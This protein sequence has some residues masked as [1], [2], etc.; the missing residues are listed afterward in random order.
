MKKN[1]YPFLAFVL[2]PLIGWTQ[3]QLHQVT[4]HEL[5]QSNALNP[6]ALSN[7]AWTITFPN[8]YNE[9]KT[10]QLSINQ[11]IRKDVSGENQLIIDEYIEDLGA[12]NNFRNVFELETFGI[13]YRN[14]NDEQWT[15]RHKIKSDISFQYPKALIELI[16]NTNPTSPTLNH[17]IF[18]HT[19]HEL[20][21]G[22]AKKLDDGLQIG[23]CFKILNGINHISANITDLQSIGND[24]KGEYLLHTSDLLEKDDLGNLNFDLTRQF[25]LQNLFSRNFG[26][27][28]DLGVQ[29]QL[30]N[31]QI[32]MS[33]LDVGQLFWNT[34]ISNFYFEG[35]FPVKKMGVAND[36]LEGET[37]FE[38]TTDSLRSIFNP[39]ETQD[40][41]I[42]NLAP[43]FYGRLSYMNNSNWEFHAA[44]YGSWFQRAFYPAISLITRYQVVRNLKLGVSYSI[45]NEEYDHLG[46][47]VVLNTDK[48][49]LFAISNDFINL[50]DWQNQEISDIQ[51]GINWLFGDK[52]L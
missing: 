43:K 11:L 15:L 12:E 40:L 41:H 37:T 51:I 38:V 3:Q 28:F 13:S 9:L 49:Q 36:Y 6:S 46:L 16:W 24:I 50:L 45:Y 29:A 10:S 5:I 42:A 1:I 17:K 4:L 32:G 39:I 35:R 22:Y 48:F 30:N 44:L 21:I 27:A 20:G 26:Y 31:W 47:S 8:L 52:R 23:G 2:F 33:V 14:E 19:Y 34:G 25:Q 18:A 7:K